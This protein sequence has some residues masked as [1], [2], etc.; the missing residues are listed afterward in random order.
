LDG[1]RRRYPDLHPLLF[2]RTV[3]RANSAGEVF[4]LLESLPNFPLVWDYDK[5]EWVTA[6]DLWLEPED[7]K[8]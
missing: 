2:Q 4:D 3:E 7:E 1:L 8:E 5:R 6:T